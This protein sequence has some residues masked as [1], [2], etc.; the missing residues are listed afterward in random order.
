MRESAQGVRCV[1][2]DLGGVLVKIAH[3]WAEGC[4]F[5]GLDVRGGS[6]GAGAG[7]ARGALS[8][9][10]GIGT[11][12]EEQY[13]ERSAQA[14]EGHYTADEIR[15]IHHAWTRQ[16]Y[17]GAHAL[18]LELNA[19]GVTTACLSN[20]NSSHWR[21]LRH[22]DAGVPLSGEPE[23]PSVLALQ[24]AHASHLFGLAKP[25]AE[26]YRAFERAT[27]FSGRDV[28]F[29]DD[30]IANVEG[31]RAIGWRAERIDP[32]SETIPQLRSLLRAYAI[33]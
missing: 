12:T 11:L 16:E 20:T 32:H 9:E 30:A 7:R 3:S 21:R 10:F 26:I 29:F 25:D 15:R 8:S 23:Y 13:Y 1:C 4:G 19:S 24:H 17:D 14:S 31:A 33:L 18:V 2:F 5:A 28:L 6:A 27:G 22:V